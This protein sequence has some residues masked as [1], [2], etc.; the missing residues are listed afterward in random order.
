MRAALS[1]LFLLILAAPAPAQVS[2]SSIH[3]QLTA[4]GYEN[5]EFTEVDGQLNLR[6]VRRKFVLESVYDIATGALLSE[7]VTRLPEGP[8]A[9]ETAIAP[10]TGPALVD[11]T[12]GDPVSPA[13]H[14]AEGKEKPVISAT[15]EP[16]AE[17][18]AGSAGGV[19]PATGAQTSSATK[20]ESAAD[21]PQN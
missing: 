5:I 11:T 10:A 7:R 13:A 16:V 6:A 3:A 15:V 17:T 12:S 9:A 4:Q 18:D 8:A 14:V 21:A 1:G 19:S 2:E 20:A